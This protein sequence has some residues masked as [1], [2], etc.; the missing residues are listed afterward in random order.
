PEVQELT[1]R[2]MDCFL[3][4]D[5]SSGFLDTPPVRLEVRNS[6]KEIHEVRYEQEWPIA[7]TDYQKLYLSDQQ[8]LALERLSNSKELAYSA[9]MGKVTFLYPFAEDTE[10]TGYMKLRLWM[11]AR[12]KPN[13]TEPPD[14]IGI[15]VAIDK[16][17]RPFLLVANLMNFLE[18]TTNLKPDRRCVQ[19]SIGC[20]SFQKT[21][22]KASSQLLNAGG[23]V[24]VPLT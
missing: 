19:E 21:I 10:L 15:Y 22:H 8:S 24:G 6:L 12:P 20:F 4:G 1:R 18:T 14:D 7:R 5:N 17:D 11:E 13:A 23:I 3:K 2:F 9:T 16:R